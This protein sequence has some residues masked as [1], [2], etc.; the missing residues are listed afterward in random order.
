MAVK[1]A[2]GR[3][4]MGSGSSS[5]KRDRSNWAEDGYFIDNFPDKPGIVFKEKDGSYPHTGIYIGNGISI[6]SSGHSVGV[7]V[8]AMPYTWTDFELP[9]NLYPKL[10]PSDEIDALADRIGGIADALPGTN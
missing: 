6:H 2:T 1:V 7:I 3:S 4:I 9:I 5:Q 8:S 10:E